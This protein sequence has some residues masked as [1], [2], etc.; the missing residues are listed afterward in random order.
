[1]YARDPNLIIISETGI[2]QEG[3]G[4][5]LMKKGVSEKRG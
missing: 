1:M 4:K 5:E 2:F 3:W